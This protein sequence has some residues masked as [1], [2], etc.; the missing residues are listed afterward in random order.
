MWKLFKI[1]LWLFV[2]LG[3]SRLANEVTD[4]TD[5]VQKVNIRADQLD[6][7]A[8]QLSSEIQRIRYFNP[9]IRTQ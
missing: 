3:I 2:I 4:L 6:S 5:K 8:N 7:R 9:Q 1:L